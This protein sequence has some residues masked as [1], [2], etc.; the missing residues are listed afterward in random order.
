MWLLDYR[1][2]P[3][4]N[5]SVISTSVFSSCSYALHNCIFLLHMSN[6]KVFL[7]SFALSLLICQKSEQIGRMQTLRLGLHIVISHCDKMYL[8]NVYEI[9][10]TWKRII[11]VVF[12][13][14]VSPG[15]NWYCSVQCWYKMAESL[16]G[17]TLCWCLWYQSI[18]Q[19]F[20]ALT[21]SGCLSDTTLACLSPSVSIHPSWRLSN[22]PSGQINSS[23]V[24]F[25]SRSVSD[26]LF[27]HFITVSAS[28]SLY[29]CFFPPVIH[30]V[31]QFARMALKI[32]FKCDSAS[33]SG[34]FTPADV[35]FLLPLSVFGLFGKMDCL[36]LNPSHPVLWWG[37]LFWA[38]LV[39]V[40]I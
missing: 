29:L 30:P 34:I 17:C 13:T 4:V 37:E 20:A 38:S 35:T 3:S 5:H 21:V 36:L 1:F 7:Q 9:A 2:N 26:C 31:Y 28:L 8:L 40:A 14:K 25:V 6:E 27:V 22:K 10:Q 12:D 32:W 11:S 16:N 33:C 18:L 15:N 24:L 39:N 19:C 23:L